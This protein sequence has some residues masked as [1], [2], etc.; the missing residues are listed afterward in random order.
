MR[1][2]QKSS[3]LPP[4]RVLLV[5]DEEDQREVMSMWL[6]QQK[7]LRYTVARTGPE[8]L[9]RAWADQP[10]VILLDLILPGMDGM[11]VLRRYKS[12][13]GPARVIVISQA[14]D[15]ATITL[16]LSAGASYYLTKPVSFPQ[17]LLHIQGLGAG[18]DRFF[19]QV[20][21]RMGANPDWKGFEQA[22]RCAAVLSRDR[23]ALLKVVYLQAA[24]ELNAEAKQIE[25]NIRRLVG[26]LH[27]VVRSPFY[28]SLVP[29]PD[30]KGAPSN[31]QF[32][33]ILIRAATIPL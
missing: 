19:Q 28:R 22:A 30:S 18:P 26:A 13:N 17:L 20:L 32:L 8:A 12:E 23:E 5:E 7:D 29:D 21:I 16:A 9:E 15:S 6:E 1:A 31:K 2:D 14:A 24:K 25:I 3:D 33:S 11:E 10:D 27:K 4:I